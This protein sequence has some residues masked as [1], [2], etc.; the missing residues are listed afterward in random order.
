MISPQAATTNEKAT[1]IKYGDYGAH[2]QA[3][4]PGLRS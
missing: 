2:F 3:V 4:S 1:L